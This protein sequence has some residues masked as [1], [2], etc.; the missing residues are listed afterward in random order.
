LIKSEPISTFLMYI[1]GKFV[2]AQSG[3]VLSSQNPTTGQD[4]ASVPDAGIEDIDSAVL[5]A[6]E[7]F[8]KGIWSTYT[9]TQRSRLL[10]KLG[11]ILTRDAELL[12]SCESK[13][14]GKLYREMLGQCVSS[15]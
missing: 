3:K 1:D 13:D 10:R 6:R 7:A 11:D 12:A 9:G 14:N 4:W 2:P 15:P 8:D 5:A